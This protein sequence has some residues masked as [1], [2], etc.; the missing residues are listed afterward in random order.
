MKK[1]LF[2]LNINFL[3]SIIIPYH[4]F[5]QSYLPNQILVQTNNLSPFE[6][7]NLTAGLGVSTSIIADLPGL[8]IEQWVFNLPVDFK[9]DDGSTAHLTSTIDVLGLVNNQVVSND[10]AGLN[11]LVTNPLPNLLANYSLSSYDPLPYCNE[12]LVI[13][14][15]NNPVSIAVIDGGINREESIFSDRVHDSE[16]Y[17]ITTG[18]N[19]VYPANYHGTLIIS[20][21]DQILGV[22][23]MNAASISMYQVFDANGT[24]ALG[25]VIKAVNLAILNQV[26]VIQMAIGYHPLPE[27]Q[28]LLL[29]TLLNHPYAQNI[30]TSISAGNEQ[31]NLNNTAYYP[32]AFEMQRTAYVVGATNCDTEFAAFSNYSP[33][34]VMIAAPGVNVLGALPGGQFFLS[35]GTS[36]ASALVTAG[37]AQLLSINPNKE[38]VVCAINNTLLYKP[39]LNDK[40][41]LRGMLWNLSDAKNWLESYPSCS[42]TSKSP[43]LCLVMK[44]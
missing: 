5:T 34:S 29:K 9:M 12:N 24:A 44:P 40:V 30:L 31:T 15:G 14:P 28:S 16:H 23:G 26:D 3:F 22:A 33:Q 7:D 25:D 43:I 35:E 13:P 2:I 8:Q 6:L 42:Q 38:N 19:D 27:D 41:R 4:S 39:W 1:I 10:N 32:A 21:I 37:M 36:Q 11:Y 18:N 20:I 17:N